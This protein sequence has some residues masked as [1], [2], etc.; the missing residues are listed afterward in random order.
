MSSINFNLENYLKYRRVAGKTVK[1]GIFTVTKF[2]NGLY[3]FATKQKL[4]KNGK[5]EN[6]PLIGKNL[7]HISGKI[8]RVESVNIHW[9]EVGYYYYAVLCDENNSHATA[10]VGNINCQNPDILKYINE[11]N[12]DYII[13]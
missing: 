10:F 5:I 11:F 2:K 6:H 4:G 12:N 13:L 7:K 8:Y 1:N 9:I 3:C